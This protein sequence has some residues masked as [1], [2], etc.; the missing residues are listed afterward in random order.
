MPRRR[1][2]FLGPLESQVMDFVWETGAT[3]AEQVRRALE[4]KQPVKDSTVRTILRR[5]EVKGYLR[6]R[7]EGRTYVYESQIDPRSVATDAV[8]G[9]IHRFCEGSVEKLLVG[10]V[11]DQ[12]LTLDELAELAMKITAAE[13]VAVRRPNRKA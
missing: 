6:H 1:Q 12:I 10:M 5:L 11:D 2:Q 13:A 3:T 9:I 8:R 4:K 7:V